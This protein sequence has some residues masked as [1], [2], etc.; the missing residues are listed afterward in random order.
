MTGKV[1]SDYS[2]ADVYLFD[3]QHTVGGDNSTN[4]D[5]TTYN[6]FLSNS[7]LLVDAKAPLIGTWGDEGRVQLTKRVFY[8]DT[9]LSGIDLTKP[10]VLE[11]AEVKTA[12]DALRTVRQ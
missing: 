10:E 1:V 12:Q 3:V 6:T 8:L 11:S 2:V 4:P 5:Q 9:Y 7:K